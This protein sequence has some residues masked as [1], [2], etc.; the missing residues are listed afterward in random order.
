MKTK[1]KTL[2]VI[3]TA[4]LIFAMT[5][6]GKKPE[7]TTASTTVAPETTVTETEATTEVATETT[8]ETTTEA[9][10]ETTEGTRIV[11]TETTIKPAAD[12]TTI[13]DIQAKLLT[14]TKEPGTETTPNIYDN[15]IRNI[16]GFIGETYGYFIVEFDPNSDEAKLGAGDTF[17][18]TSYSPL[19]ASGTRTDPET[20]TA[21]YNNYVIVIFDYASSS[22]TAPF[23]NPNAQAVYDAFVAYKG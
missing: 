11:A 21:V 22:M 8:T 10:V 13:E 19:E 1:I 12:A 5:A 16:R 3:M 7:E 20:I 14:V 18:L 23:D 9:T 17:M 15:Y 2:A 4:T 6:C